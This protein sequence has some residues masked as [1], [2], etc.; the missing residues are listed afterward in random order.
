MPLVLNYRFTFIDAADSEEAA[1]GVRHRRVLTPPPR[2][3]GG[4]SHLGED[5]LSEEVEA[6]RCRDYL[7]GLK[8][9]RGPLA[10][11]GGKGASNRMPSGSKEPSDAAS[12]APKCPSEEVSVGSLGHPIACRRPCVHMA[13]RRQCQNGSAC[14]YCHFPHPPEVKLNKEQRAMVHQLP[15]GEFLRIVADVLK[16]RAG[17]VAKPTV[18]DAVYLLEEEVQL[19]GVVG[20]QSDVKAV[21]KFKKGLQHLNILSLLAL[22]KRRCRDSVCEVLTQLAVELRFQA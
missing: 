21:K 3:P 7:S 10:C 16:T 9:E 22:A 17:N 12:A 5:A 8:D 6:A 18:W 2:R 4:L 13:Q 14:G 15:Y 19:A 11:N 20:A 1:Q